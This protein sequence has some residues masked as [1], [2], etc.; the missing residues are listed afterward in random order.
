MGLNCGK[1]DVFSGV[2][3]LR[4]DVLSIELFWPRRS[5]LNGCLSC[6]RKVERG[7]DGVK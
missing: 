6:K 1:L 4:K 3:G 5:H 2:A 7:G